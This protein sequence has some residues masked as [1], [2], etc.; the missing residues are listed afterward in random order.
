VAVL[1][2]GLSRERCTRPVG[3]AGVGGT[4]RCDGSLLKFDAR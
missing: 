1:T 4:S 2:G 3:S